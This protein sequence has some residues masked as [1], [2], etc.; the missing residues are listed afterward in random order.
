MGINTRNIKLLAFALGAS[1]G[2]VAGG[3][4]ASLQGFVSPESFGLLES[5][6]VLCMVVL[7]GM[8]HV[9]GVLLGALLLTTL[10]EILRSTASPIQRA[11]FG[12]VYVDPEALRM[13]LFGLALILVMLVRP[14]GLW[15]SPQRKKT[16]DISAAKD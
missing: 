16:L 15:P 14:T 12:D 8:G 9:Y 13:L 1:F 4:F 6:M 7:G 10:P 5:I 11:L 2:G 3:L